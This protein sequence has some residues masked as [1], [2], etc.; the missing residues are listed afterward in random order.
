[1]KTYCIFLI[2]FIAGFFF[3]SCDDSGTLPP[4]TPR[5]LINFTQKNLRTLDPNVDGVYELWI[6]QDSA[7]IQTYWSLGRFNI[8][9]NNSIVELDGSPKTFSYL[10]DTNKLYLST[11][12]LVSIEKSGF[13]FVPSPVHI[14]STIVTVS[15]DSIY[16]SLTMAGADALGNAAANM[17]TSPGGMYTLQTPSATSAEC[18]Q[19]IWFCSVT[20]DTVL[21]PDNIALVPGN[22]W[23]Y[24]GWVA[25]TSQPENPVY[26]SMGRFYDPRNAD[27]DGAGPCAGP[28]P[29]Y[30]LPGQDWI[31]DNCPSGK[32]KITNLSSGYYQVF[33]TIEPE[34]ESIGS[35]AYETPFYF[36]LFRQGFIDRTLGCKR[37]DNMFNYPKQYG[38]FPSGR[39]VIAN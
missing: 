6:R 5:G 30:N 29:G 17:F 19:G 11:V 18:K 27:D 22:G 33:V 8:G 20:G 24:Q 37:T 23:V 4:N 25:D 28:N 13:N 26:Y 3:S 1:M 38:L 9:A 2:V 35:M 10:G 34:D 39:L 14:I 15:R 36:K 32:P 16:G 12:V 31:L 7:E 21:M